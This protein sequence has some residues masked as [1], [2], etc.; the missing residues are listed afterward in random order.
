MPKTSPENA[1]LIER[2]RVG[3]PLKGSTFAEWR[4]EF[5]ELYKDFPV[6]PNVHRE[7]VQ[8]AGV[9]GEWF[10]APKSTP[11][12]T[13]LYFH[14]GG[15]ALGSTRSHQALIAD[16]AIAAQIDT[17]GVNYRLSPEFPFP[18]GLEDAVAAYR[19]LLAA[20]VASSQ[21]AL[22]GDS[23]GGGM[24]AALVLAIKE[25]GLPLPGCA[26]LISAWLDLTLTLPTIRENAA[27]DP[28][29]LYAA[30]EAMAHAYVGDGDRKRP[31]ASPL[32][33]DWRNSIP[34]LIQVGGTEILLDDSREL[35]R[36]AK[37]SGVEV[38]LDVADGCI[39]GWH[40]YAHLHP[41]GRAAIERAASYIRKKLEGC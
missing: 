16:L 27:N 29:V 14:G 21:I 38:T 22:A 3:P 35:A 32:Y 23:A 31:L 40:Q 7:R 26:V 34:L 19:Y 28:V 5:E 4:A 17:F 1:A 15:Y 39:H 36:R 30:I 2:L 10:R 37:K 33:G 12:T 24:A 20:G 13:I 41:E 25:H 8:A 6:S 18:A 9:D 11:G